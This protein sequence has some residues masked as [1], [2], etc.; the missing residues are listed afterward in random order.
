M[1]K[2]G[3]TKT[4]T[5]LCICAVCIV[6]IS[7]ISRLLASFLAGQVGLSLTWLSNSEDRFSCDLAQFI[8]YLTN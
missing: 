5:D 8:D 3:T 2:P 6:V 1:T 4:Q 7:K